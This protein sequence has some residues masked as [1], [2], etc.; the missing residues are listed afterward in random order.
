MAPGDVVEHI[1]TVVGAGNVT[2]GASVNAFAIGRDSYN[3]FVSNVAATWTLGTRDAMPL[4]ESLGFRDIR[5]PGVYP[6]T[7][8]MLRR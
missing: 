6:N 5:E 7:F 2:A 8:M 1:H 4:Y 3:N